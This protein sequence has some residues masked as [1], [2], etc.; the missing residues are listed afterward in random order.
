MPAISGS[1]VLVIGGSSGIGAAVAKLVA[2]EPDVQV[3][4]ASSN[5]ARVDE[6]VGKIK[7]A[8]PS[9]KVT[10]Y[11]CNV[12]GDDAEANLEDLLTKIVTATGRP[13]DH[14]VYTAVKLDFKFLQ[15]VTIYWLRG[16]AQFLVLVPILIAKL[17]PR[18]IKQAYT[19]SLTFTSGRIAEK[20]MKGAA[21]PAA[22]GAALF[23]LVRTLA[24]DLAPIRV[25]LVSPGTTDTEIQGSEEARRGRMAAAAE[26]ALLG[27]VGTPEEVGEAYLYLMKDSNNTGTC[28]S[29]SGG[30]LIQ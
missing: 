4:I 11:T 17:A 22:W 2:A 30:A 13:L 9:A 3:S 29:T 5:A 10:G 18:Y 24:L 19:S 16:D 15:D 23:G 27:K 25:N 6:A 21:V 1:N 7:S 8:I 28:V 20:P 14:V 26:T 12:G